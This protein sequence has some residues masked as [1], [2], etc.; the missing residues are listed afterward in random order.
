MSRIGR[1]PIPVPEGVKVDIQG[2][3]VSIE[4]PQG[5]LTRKLR[6]EIKIGLKDKEIVVERTSNKRF[7]RSLH[8][9]S[10]TLIAN[11]VEGVTQGYKRVLEI[12]G[13][14]Y[15]AEIKGKILNLS[16]GFSLPILFIPPDGIKIELEGP[17]KIVVQGIDKEL[18]GLVASQIRSFRSPDPYKGKGIRY[19]DE[20]VRKKAGKTAI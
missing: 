12:K 14:G 4:G 18:V 16:L 19:Q 10:R 1:N 5:K 8:G 15:K 20:K 3:R 7:D 2:N 17:T 6:P 13:I 11:M 9:L